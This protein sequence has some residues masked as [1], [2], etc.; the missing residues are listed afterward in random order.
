MLIHNDN[1]NIKQIAESGQC[2]R[3]NKLAED[4]Y[5]LIAYG[6][7]LE[8]VQ[9]DENTVEI[10]CDEMEFHQLWEEYFD[11][12]YDYGSIVQSILQ[13]E[14][15]FLKEAV[16][17]GK[18]IRIIK[19]EPFEAAISFIISQNKNI[20]AIKNC[21]EAICKRYGE[22]KV[23]EEG[24]GAGYYSFPSPEIL[25][26]ATREDLR[27]LKTGY[28]D[29]YIISAAQ[30]VVDGKVDFSYL[31]E[32]SYED[33]VKTL[34]SIHGIGEKVANCISLYGLHH[35]EVFPIDVWIARV[36][37]EIYNND[38]HQ[39]KYDG[40][41]GIIQQYMFYYMRYLKGL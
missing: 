23:S 25:A 1:F 10:S 20:P 17:Y 35:I 27:E 40:Y 34:K 7:Y 19:Q 36:L 29:A 5:S 24:Q 2:F 13:G 41:A 30:A 11:L 31:K 18:G 8:L 33:A 16:V 37:S 22:R 32:S 15:N 6:R 3:M 4:K 28:R 9:K 12:R 26:L 38:F 14:D 39:E 21:I